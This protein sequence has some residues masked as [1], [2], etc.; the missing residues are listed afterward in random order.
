MTHFTFQFSLLNNWYAR[1]PNAD[2]FTVS[3]RF[4]Q[5]KEG[6]NSAM[7]GIFG[8]GDCYQVGIILL[9]RYVCK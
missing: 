9:E 7:E 2:S 3:L 1:N 8:N 5:T 6:Y 4:W